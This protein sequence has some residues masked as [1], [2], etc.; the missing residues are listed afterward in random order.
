MSFLR[1]RSADGGKQRVQR[2]KLTREPLFESEFGGSIVADLPSGAGKTSPACCTHF[3]L[4]DSIHSS[5]FAHPSDI[6]SAC[7]H[8]KKYPSHSILHGLLTPIQTVGDNTLLP[9]KE[10]LLRLENRRVRATRPLIPP[11]I[12]QEELPLYARR[13]VTLICPARS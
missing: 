12:L 2:K 8:T 6:P 7:L 5:P 4:F 3:S 1:C 11:Q 13:G 9:F 10:A